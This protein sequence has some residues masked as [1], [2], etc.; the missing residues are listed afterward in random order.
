VIS[1]GSGLPIWAILSAGE[2]NRFDLP[3]L[4]TI[5]GLPGLDRDPAGGPKSMLV[6]SAERPGF[7]MS[8]FSYLDLRTF[9]W[10][11]WSYSLLEL[12]P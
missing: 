6:V 3:D 5:T 2:L 7:E 11:A 12:P 8:R 10:R 4:D 1:N 9:V